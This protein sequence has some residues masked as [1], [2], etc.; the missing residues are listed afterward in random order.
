[1]KVV[2]SGFYRLQ[3]IL[4]LKLVGFIP[5]VD[6]Y[7]SLASSMIVRRHSSNLS[8]IYSGFLSRCSHISP[9]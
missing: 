5:V 8:E 1:M 4:R 2:I 6:R 7:P 9:I 3:T